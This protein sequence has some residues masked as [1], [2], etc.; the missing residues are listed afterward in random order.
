MDNSQIKSRDRISDHGEVFTAEREV[1][2]MCDM[3][4]DACG[5]ISSRI[6]E[7]ACGDG[8]FLAEILRR[9]LKTVSGSFPGI[10]EEWTRRAVEAVSSLYGVEL[11]PDNAEDCRKRLLVLWSDSYAVEFGYK[12]DSGLVDVVEFIL[13]ENILCGDALTLLDAN[14]IPLAFPLW[15]MSDD[16]TVS[17]KD[18]ELATLLEMQRNGGQGD[19]FLSSGTFD[20][21]TGAFLPN[22]VKEYE[23]VPYM[24]VRTAKAS[25]VEPS[26]C[27]DDDVS[28]AL[29]FDVVIGNPPYQKDDGGAQSS[30]TPLYHLFVRNAILLMPAMLAM[31]IPSRWFAGGKG[32]DGFREEMIHDDRLCVIHDFPDAS[33][34]FP[35]VE[36]KGGVNY[37]LWKR[38]HHGP[39]RIYTHR[40][41]VA[42][43]EMERPL[44]EPGCV[45]FIRCNEAVSILRKVRSHNETPFSSKVNSAMFFGLRTFF[46]DF[47]SDQPEDGTVLLYA[48]LSQGYVRRERIL[49]NA[50][51]IDRWK[52]IVPEATGTGNTMRDRL[53]PILSAPG[54]A[55]TETYV[56][57]GPWKD[58]N[59]AENVIAYI[60]TRFFHFLLGLMKI[61]QHTT[62]RTYSLIPMQDFSRRW[63]DAELFSKYGLTDD[64]IRFIEESVWPEAKA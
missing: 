40:N 25:D 43:S 29:R 33:E 35:D 54:S 53:K 2:A 10:S 32:L 17:R 4:G 16:G 42:V 24:S 19:L 36:I 50:E 6:L 38:D 44:V 48:N 26:W 15:Q 49:R 30:A 3:V 8:N 37:F 27:R 58:R 34:C 21:E 59:E 31:I 28:S 7:P 64:E 63:T 62:S 18:F 14:G 46:R 61:T 57:N 60:G 5:R 20:H 1:K 11:L 9:K 12:P 55:N 47:D 13:H 45:S 23:T 22:P 56:M 51:C 41:G 39:C 52:V